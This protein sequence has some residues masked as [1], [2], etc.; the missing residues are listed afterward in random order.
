MPLQSVRCGIMEG[1]VVVTPTEAFRA[2]VGDNTP[3]STEK[4]GTSSSA[5]FNKVRQDRYHL[6][7]CGNV[8]R[9]ELCE[10]R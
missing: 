6:E 5:D 9:V 2:A 7:R 8:I 3:C 10:E 4:S 1:S